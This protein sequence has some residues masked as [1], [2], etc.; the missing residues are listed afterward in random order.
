MRSAAGG[1][2]GAP[3]SQR[4]TRLKAT[5]ERAFLDPRRECRLTEKACPSLPAVRNGTLPHPDQ[6]SNR[7]TLTYSASCGTRASQEVHL[8]ATPP[9]R[10][11][12]L[13]RMTARI[14]EFLKNRTD[15]GPC[16][17]LDLDVV[18]ENY[19]GF[20]KALPDTKVFYAVKAN[21]APEILQAARRARLLL[22]RRLGERDR[23]TCSRP[24]P[25]PS[26]SPTATR[27]RR[28]ARSPPPSSSA[29]RCS[30]STARPRSRRSRARR[31]AA[32]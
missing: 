25:R 24:A 15:D 11:G 23:R 32:A 30:P 3:R 14:R 27:S 12:E 22:R 20:A 8:A 10:I 16:L 9:R 7:V 17:V 4:G 1:E 6:G 31:P 5:T 28:R 18:R 26:A 2:T 29:S 13:G 19:L 21:P